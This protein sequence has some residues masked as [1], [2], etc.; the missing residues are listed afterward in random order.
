M[1]TR[2]SGIKVYNLSN[3]TLI[4]TTQVECEYETRVKKNDEIIIDIPTLLEK[5]VTMRIV[6]EEGEED[7]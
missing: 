3:R 1:S 6:I 2:I 5:D 4:I 7:D